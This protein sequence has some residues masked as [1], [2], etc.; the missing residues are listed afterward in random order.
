MRIVLLPTLLVFAAALH[1][2]AAEVSSAAA[3]IRCGDT[4]F[5]IKT[6]FRNDIAIEQT[7]NA[8]FVGRGGS[9]KVDLR[10]TK[11]LFPFELRDIKA[12]SS[13]VTGWQCKKTPT[14]HVLV[15]WYA[16]RQDLREDLPD[17]LCSQTLEWERYISTSG[18][19][20]DYGYSFDDPR[21]VG[22]RARLGY[23]DNPPDQATYEDP[24]IS[25]H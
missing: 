6:K 19:V 20:L 14:G 8:R 15:L 3:S 21:Y 25:T 2:Q 11:V 17:T 13:S 4:R 24:F 22:L 10:Q 23:H 7:L 12:P 1:S 16:C 18:D 9:K 5:S